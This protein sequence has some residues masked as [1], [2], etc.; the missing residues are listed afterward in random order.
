MH[1]CVLCTK[2]NFAQTILTVLLL[3]PWDILRQKW[4]HGEGFCSKG[5]MNTCMNG[6]KG[7]ASSE[8]VKSTIDSLCHALAEH[9]LSTLCK[10]CIGGLK[11]APASPRDN[12]C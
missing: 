12:I 11:G 10:Y 1:C 9:F 3:P 4:F 2:I 5:Q 6:V 8:T 7:R